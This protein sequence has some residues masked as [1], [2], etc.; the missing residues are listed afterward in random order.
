MSYAGGGTGVDTIE[1]YV[2]TNANSSRDF[3]EDFATVSI[4]IHEP[5]DYLAMGDSYATG[6]AR[7]KGLILV[8]N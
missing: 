1:A 3:G 5:V 6:E 7:Q 8:M 2:D 4:T